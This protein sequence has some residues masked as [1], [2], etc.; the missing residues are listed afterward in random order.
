MADGISLHVDLH[1]EY[2][3]GLERGMKVGLERVG[4]AVEGVARQLAPVRTGRLRRSIQGGAKQNRNSRGQFQSG[5]YVTVGSDVEYAQFV[6]QGTRYMQA[7]P[8][9][10]PALNAVM[11]RAQAIIA[12][13][14]AEHVGR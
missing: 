9:L 6:E 14:I 7:Q 4:Q 2:L 1:Q 12:A 11:P 5:W 13:A 3:R 8:Y 10:E